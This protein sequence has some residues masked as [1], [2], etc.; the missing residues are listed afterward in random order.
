MTA[1]TCKP[2]TDTRT[3]LTSR[4]VLNA[5]PVVPVMVIQT[6]EDAVPLAQ[7]LVA[8]GIRVLEITLRTPIALEAIRLIADQVKDAIVGAGTVITPDQLAAATDAGAMF[9]ISPG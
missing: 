8:G 1:P 7:A 3:R 2:I 6:L 4:D 5:G 9:A